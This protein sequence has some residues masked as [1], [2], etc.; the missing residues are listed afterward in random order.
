MNNN[1]TTIKE[2]LDTWTNQILKIEITPIDNRGFVHFYAQFR[3]NKKRIEC[4][5]TDEETEEYLA[6]LHNMESKLLV[7]LHIARSLYQLQNRSM[8]LRFVESITAITIRKL[9]KV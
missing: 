4:Y 5:L 1:I 3:I 9:P 6:T 2:F 8:W 7:A